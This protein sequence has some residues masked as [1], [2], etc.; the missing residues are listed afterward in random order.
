[1]NKLLKLFCVSEIIGD[2]IITEDQELKESKWEDARG[3][4]IFWS[5]AAGIIIFAILPWAVGVIDIL[6]WIF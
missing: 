5:I 6:R 3:A 1:M 2:D 4:V